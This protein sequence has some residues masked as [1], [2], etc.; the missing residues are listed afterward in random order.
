MISMLSVLVLLTAFPVGYLIAWLT[1]D[2]LIV[3]RKWI[4]LLGAASFLFM[5]PSIFIFEFKLPV[6]LT[7]MYLTIVCLVI[8][9]KS[10]D[11]KFMRKK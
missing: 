5:L 11:K 7:L 6:L 8:L 4:L 9:S 2:E 10:Y 3:G 1:K